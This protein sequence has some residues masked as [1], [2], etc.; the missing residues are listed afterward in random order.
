[1]S[2]TC[3]FNTHTNTALIPQHSL[4][5][6]AATMTATFRI[7]TR[8][9]RSPFTARAVRPA[10]TTTSSIARRFASSDYGSGDGNPVGENPQDQGPSRSS[11]IEHPG[12]SAPDVGQGQS[13][14]TPTKEGPG[15]STYSSGKGGSTGKEANESGGV[16][17]SGNDGKTQSGES[18][19]EKSESDKGSTQSKNGAQPK[20]NTEPPKVENQKEV[21]EHNADVSRRSQGSKLKKEEKSDEVGKGF[22]AGKW[23]TLIQHERKLIS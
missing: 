12:P 3:I 20:L 6:D 2:I 5:I 23:T 11:Q 22:W 14:S 18:T 4:T 17:K 7:L 13:G 16:S 9:A 8:A 21:D 15:G 19:P 10:Q 1:M